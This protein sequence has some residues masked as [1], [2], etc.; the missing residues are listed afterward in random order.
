MNDHIDFPNKELIT[1]YG[2]CAPRYTSYPPATQFH[3]QFGAVE[4]Q[5]AL[6]S[7]NMYDPW[8]L[9]VHIPFCES[10]CYYC[11]CNKTVTKHYDQAN[12]YIDEVQHELDLL[13]PFLGNMAIVQQLHWGGGTPTFLSHDAMRTLM[14]A[15]KKR[16]SFQ[17]EDTGE[18]SVEIDPRHAPDETLALLRHIGFNR[19]SIGVQDF[20]P[21]VQKA[22][23]REQPFSLVRHVF[24]TARSLGF[25]S[26]NVDLIYGLPH[27]NPAT[28]TQTL[29]KLLDL[30]PERIS[31]FNY[32]HLPSRF[33]AQRRINADALPTPDSKIDILTTTINTLTDA[34]YIYIGLDHFAKTTDELAIAHRK[35]NI[36]RNFQGYSTHGHLDVLGIGASAV[37][38]IGNIYSQ[39]V[40]DLDKYSD[41]INNNFLPTRRGFTL[42]VDDCLRRE[43]INSFLCTM[44]CDTTAFE[45]RH[46][47]HFSTYFGEE[48]K[49]LE[50]F[51]KDG[52]VTM[53]DGIQVTA[54]GQML[55][56]AICAVF[57][58]YLAAVPTR[59][60]S[61]V[62]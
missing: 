9:Y 21:K 26:L 42:T 18:Y 47:L 30:S 12:R 54:R 46:D 15:I 23:H 2:E 14:S 61:R 51:I 49:R 34:G 50:P 44:R 22:I 60:F 5:A 29:D 48:L 39:N 35:G 37:S 45:D 52:L 53:T 43:V 28:F 38:R 58:R 31:V 41:L 10:V 19:L 11:A 55:V 4:F 33:K 27:Q 1:R 13:A 8:S 3:E 20:D 56:R 17:D 62:I 6:A 57:D 16:F 25:R 40:T 24:N 7:R 32:A 36:A 59:Q